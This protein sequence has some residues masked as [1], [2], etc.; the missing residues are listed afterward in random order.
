MRT[1][2]DLLVISALAVYRCWRLVARD[3]I[4]S[5]WR[6]RV[7]NRWPPTA[8][9]ATGLMKWEPKLRQNVFHARPGEPPK[10]SGLAAAVD[11]PW[12]FGAWLCVPATLAVDAS[13]G[14]V[15]PVAWFLAL[16][17]VVGLLGRLDAAKSA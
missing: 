16:S 2:L 5:Q 7:Y 6:E 1:R 3:D 11:C 14:L 9:R 10:V 4:T 13:F 12:C 8:S 17:T 15:W